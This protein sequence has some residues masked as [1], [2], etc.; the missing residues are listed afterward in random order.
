[1]CTHV[2]THLSFGINMLTLCSI[3][4]PGKTW[5]NAYLHQ[6]GHKQMAN[7]LIPSLAYWIKESIG[8]Y[9]KESGEES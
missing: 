7:E 5:T 3:T 2:Y 8:V 1:M 4:S 6:R 9:L